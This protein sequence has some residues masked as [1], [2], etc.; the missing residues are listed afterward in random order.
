M[1]LTNSTFDPCSRLLDQQ[2][3]EASW[4]RVSHVEDNV[5]TSNLLQAARP[6]V[7]WIEKGPCVDMGWWC[8]VLWIPNLLEANYQGWSGC[9][10]ECYA[11]WPL[12]FC[13]F[14][15]A[16]QEIDEP[17]GHHHRWSWSIPTHSYLPICHHAIS[18]VHSSPYICL[19][20]IQT[21]F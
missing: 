5:R 13:P 10:V 7:I 20:S 14:T 18:T 17:Y 12:D 8:M 1:Q 4:F 9:P 2:A 19:E 21:S 15:T 16:G 11:S 6:W 3:S